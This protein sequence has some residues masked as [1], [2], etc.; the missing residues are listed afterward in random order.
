MSPTGLS[1]AHPAQLAGRVPPEFEPQQHDRIRVR[2]NQEYNRDYQDQEYNCDHRVGVPDRDGERINQEHEHEYNRG[3][4][5]EEYNQDCNQ[6]EYYQDYHVS[7]Y[8]YPVPSYTIPQQSQ[9]EY[10]SNAFPHPSFIDPR[11]TGQYGSYAPPGYSPRYGYPVA[12]PL[13]L[14][15]PAHPVMMNG[16]SEWPP[17]GGH[18]PGGPMVG[19][20][21]RPL[22][23]A[24]RDLSPYPS[25][26]GG[27]VQP[28]P[29]MGHAQSS[30]RVLGP[31]SA[32]GNRPYFPPRPVGYYNER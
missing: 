26:P 12:R 3:Y 15:D 2:V 32:D 23:Y 19:I 20:G 10:S 30:G 16:Q 6:Q 1:T 9:N 25:Q 29:V 21:N 7:Q 8:A 18:Y 14:R 17:P 24:S 13:V 27:F 5:Q 22:A 11:L 31:L 4:N 28:V